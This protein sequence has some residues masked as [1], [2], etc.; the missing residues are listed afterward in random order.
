MISTYIKTSINS[1]FFWSKC[2]S[3]VCWAASIVQ[4]CFF[5]PPQVFRLI[6]KSAFRWNHFF[7]LVLVFFFFF[8]ICSIS[9]SPITAHH[10]S[11]DFFALLL[12]YAT[13][14][15]T[16]LAWPA[17]RPGLATAFSSSLLT[18]I[19]SCT[20]KVLKNDVNYHHHHHH[21]HWKKQNYEKNKQ[22]NE[23][24]NEPAA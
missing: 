2:N 5:F 22:T 9:H 7:V 6:L 19:H 1:K 10:N 20:R 15:H 17:P 14:F 18:C 21:H 24:T 3:P 4:L 16:G 11:S 8:W 12:R 13:D 23:T